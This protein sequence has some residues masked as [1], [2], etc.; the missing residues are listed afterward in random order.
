MSPEQALGKA[1]D[2][3]SDIFSLGSVIYELLT[4]RPPFA[5]ANLGEILDKIVHDQPDGHRPA[6]LRRPARAGA[7]HAQVPGETA[8]PPLPVGSRADGGSAEPGQGA[9]TWRS[10]RRARRRSAAWTGADRSAGNRGGI[11]AEPFSLEKLKTSDVLLNYAA[12]DDSAAARRQAGLG[13][14]VASQPG[15]A[16]GAAFGRKGRHRPPAG[17]PRSR[18]RSR[19]KLLEQVP[20]AKAMISVVSPPFIRSDVCRREVEQFW[21]GA[22]QTGGRYIKDKSRL[23]KVLKTAVSEQQM[24]RRSLDIFSPLFGFEFFELD[25]ETGRVREF[26]ETFGPVLKQRFFERVYDLAYDGCQVLSLLQQVRAATVA[27]GRAG[28]ESAMGLSGR[29]PR[30]MSQDERDR[31]R[32]ELLER[33]HVVLPDAP[34]PML[35][36]DVETVVRDAWPSAPSPSICW[37]GVTA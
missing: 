1:L 11:A 14:A 34:L 30:R 31:I 4:G 17:V 35:S 5:G 22:E 21:R 15:S 33:G 9:R 8:R 36:R 37:A 27:G 13:V 26:D 7:D 18:R 25:A 10:G 23:L 16:D 20:Q 6:Q 28:P 24:P 12:I 32:R 19:P 3:R 29:R 2:H